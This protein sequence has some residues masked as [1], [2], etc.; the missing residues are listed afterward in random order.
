MTR[1]G[2]HRGRA[3]SKP[4]SKRASSARGIATIGVIGCGRLGSSLALALRAAGLPVAA[5]A[6]HSLA[7]A[8]RLAQR[9]LGA[10][11]LTP[12]RLVERCGLVVLAVPDDA[13]EALCM[14][15]AFRPG[16]A[17]VHCSG[18]LPLAVLDAAAAR[19][20]LRGCVHPLQSFPT[21]AGSPERLHGIHCGVD[22]DPALH[23]RLTRLVR[24]LGA[25]PLSL[26]G[27]DRARYHAAA[28]LASNYVVALHAAAE[29][30]FA[31]SGL[32]R[33]HARRALAP[34]TLGTATA[35]RAQPLEHALTGPL[36][37]GDVRTLQRHLDALAARPELRA[38]YA[39]L[40]LLLLARPLGLPAAKRR[41]LTRL[42]KAASR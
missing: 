40:G 10:T 39:Q 1:A 26:R 27:V 37:R 16:Q 7:A 18:A 14:R 5:V 41:Q 35:I 32:P 13:I 2:R 31:L 8:R 33:T 15:L 4:A 19:G 21:K 34:L 28:V 23:T 11:A 22:A 25:T 30:A 20:A 29:E 12:A 17:V 24:A 6:D 9:V 38:L 42:F 3:A 36:A